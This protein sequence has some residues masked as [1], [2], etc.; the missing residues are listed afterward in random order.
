MEVQRTGFLEQ[1][2]TTR[3]ALIIATIPSVYQD[4]NY[5]ISFAGVGI[6]WSIAETILTFG[7]IRDGPVTLVEDYNVG[8]V[9]FACIIRG[10]SEGAAILSMSWKPLTKASVSALAI[11]LF[12]AVFDPVDTIVLS[13]R[14]VLSPP[15]M[16]VTFIFSFL[17]LFRV[18]KEYNII[19]SDVVWRMCAIAFVWNSL[20]IL[21]GSR[22]VRPTRRT[23]AF[24][25]YD[26]LFE[27]G[28]LY[29][30]IAEVVLLTRRAT[31]RLKN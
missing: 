20:A 12:D 17:Y 5:A 3:I 9:L 24:V 16:I 10:F 21:G 2:Y 14:N 23:M 25:L 19:R 8:I 30:G 6:V 28:L 22:N 7:R 27:V 18:F 13:T 15:G 4:S 31:Q 26:S 1:G 29:A 11:L